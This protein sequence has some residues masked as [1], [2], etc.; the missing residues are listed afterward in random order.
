VLLARLALVYGYNLCLAL[1]ASVALLPVVPVRLLGGVIIG[2]LAPMTF[3]SALALVLSLLLG[4]TNA[5]SI[6]LGVWMARGLASTMV[7]EEGVGV[8]LSRMAARYAAFWHEPALLLGL[9]LAL[10]LGAIWLCSRPER[11]IVRVP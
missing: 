8:V 3:L 10:L 11:Q 6:A 7:S 4:T 2:W 1:A 9:S 5:I